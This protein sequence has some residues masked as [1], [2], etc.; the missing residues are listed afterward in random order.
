[1]YLYSNIYVTYFARFL[2][3]YPLQFHET[4]VYLGLCWART[5]LVSNKSNIMTTGWDLVPGWNENK[6]YK[7]IKYFDNKL[8]NNIFL[9]DIIITSVV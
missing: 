8:C 6:I 1:M 3:V 7:I 4:S 9:Q 5:S 2:Y